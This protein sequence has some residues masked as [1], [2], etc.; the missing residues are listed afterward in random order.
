MIAR[1][2]G[3]ACAA[4]SLE[5][6]LLDFAAHVN[7]HPALRSPLAGWSPRFCI[8]A[9]DTGETFQV[10][11]ADGVVGRITPT[12][13]EPEDDALLLRGE[14]ALIR[15]IFSGRTSPLAAYTDGQLEVYGSPK[16]QIKLDVIALVLWGA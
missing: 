12:T 13:D 7:A 1:P 4:P 2:Q 8:Q 3:A 9:C 16:D 14:Q 15:R 6:V 10:P 11:I 5:Q